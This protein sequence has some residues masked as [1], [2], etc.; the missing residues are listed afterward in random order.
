MNFGQFLDKYNELKLK[1]PHPP[2]YILKCENSDYGDY[3]ADCKNAFFCF[4][5]S[6]SQN[7]IYLFDSYRA[8]NCCDGDYIVESE[9]CYE[10]I[11]ILKAY[12]CTYLNYCAR[13]Y[14]SHFCYDCNDSNNLFGCVYLNFKKY[15]IF[16]RQ[17]S[18]DEYEKKVSELI[19]KRPEENLKEMRKLLPRFP[20]SVTN[21]THA[22]NSDYGNHVHYSKNMYLCFD[23]ARSENCAYCYDS[24]QNKN[25]Y[26][27]TQTFIS[28][29]SYES[30]D[31]VTIH[32]SFYMEGC[33]DVYDSGFCEYCDQSHHLFGCFGLVHKEYCLLN[34]QYSKEEY[35]KQ[36]K[37]IMKS[38]RETSSI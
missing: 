9:N 19:G 11:D 27:L 13:I 29:F 28:E 12:N 17:Y 34:K 24:H 30:I 6:Y 8:I 20:V 38:L 25:C 10:C 31:S 15:C 14:D 33:T 36:V 26:D 1:Y 18:K 23:A 4:D 32:N 16:N 35:E 7:I 3:L 2:P 37:E 21:V 22:E 5:T